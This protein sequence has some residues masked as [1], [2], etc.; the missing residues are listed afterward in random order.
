[1][2]SLTTRHFLHYR[3]RTSTVWL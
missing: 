1:M 3:I 2:L